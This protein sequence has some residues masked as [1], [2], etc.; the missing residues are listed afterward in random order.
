MNAE[1]DDAGEPVPELEAQTQWLQGL[2]AASEGGVEILTG[3]GPTQ[4]AGTPQQDRSVDAR[5]RADRSRTVE[6]RTLF[7]SDRSPLP[8]PSRVPQETDRVTEG[9]R[10]ARGGGE[11][12]PGPG[13]GA[14][15]LRG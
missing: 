6:R 11:A 2:C 14:G 5:T 7:H 13:S 1:M 3:H 4:A 8:D 10:C 15:C 12:Q 9:R